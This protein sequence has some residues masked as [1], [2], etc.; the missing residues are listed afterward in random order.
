MGIKELK[1]SHLLFVKCVLN[2][3]GFKTKEKKSY[4][5][6]IKHVSCNVF[7]IE[8]LQEQEMCAHIVVMSA[9]EDAVV[10]SFPFFLIIYTPEE[11]VAGATARLQNGFNASFCFANTKYFC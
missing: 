7:F 2:F 1:W 6:N 10:F 9:N 4:H 5:H 3:A 11:D 8:I